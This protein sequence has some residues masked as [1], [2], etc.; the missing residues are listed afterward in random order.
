MISTPCCRQNL[1]DHLFA[2]RAAIE[3]FFEPPKGRTSPN[4]LPRANCKLLGAFMG[5]SRP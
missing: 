4:S 1:N 5:A 2:S 3:Y